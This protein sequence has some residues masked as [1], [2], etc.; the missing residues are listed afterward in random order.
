MILNEK[1]VN[2]EVE[3]LCLDYFSIQCHF[4]IVKNNFKLFILAAG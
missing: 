1:V 3:D 2:Y 4:K